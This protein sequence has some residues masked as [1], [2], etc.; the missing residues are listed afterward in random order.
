MGMNILVDGHL[1][2]GWPLSISS[3]SGRGIALR[4]FQAFGV[5]EML[6]Y[7]QAWVCFERTCI[8]LLAERIW[9]VKSTKIMVMAG[10]RENESQLHYPHL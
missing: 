1:L 3:T 6:R 5:R 2:D 8:T 4:I 10:I 9:C 7:Y